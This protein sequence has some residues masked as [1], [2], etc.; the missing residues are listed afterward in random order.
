MYHFIHR[1]G[2]AMATN[3]PHTQV[4]AREALGATSHSRTHG[5]TEHRAG[6]SLS[7]TSAAVHS[8]ELRRI[9][10]EIPPPQSLKERISPRVGLGKS[11]EARTHGT[12]DH[13][14]GDHYMQ[15]AA[16]LTK[17]ARRIRIENTPPRRAMPQG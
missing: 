14:P 9:R 4:Q 7:V 12:A 1:Q 8:K 5:G 15:P 2:H 17:E 13:R 6:E 3:D 10:L 16:P 11:L